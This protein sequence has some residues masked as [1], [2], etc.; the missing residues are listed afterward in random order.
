MEKGWAEV[1]EREHGAPGREGEGA[2]GQKLGRGMASG[3][4]PRG[5]EG[6]GGKATWQIVGAAFIRRAQPQCHQAWG[7]CG[8]Y[9]F[10]SG[11]S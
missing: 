10:W 5:P 2:K 9:S 1:K 11:G 4:A 7:G 8:H 3:G 6:C